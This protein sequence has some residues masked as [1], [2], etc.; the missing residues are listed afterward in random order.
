[1]TNDNIAINR[2]KSLLRKYK[3]GK[4]TLDNLVYII[5]DQGYEIIEYSLNE[6]N[7]ILSSLSLENYSQGC[8]AFSYN[9]NG[10]KFVFIS[11]DTSANEKTYALSHELGH[12]ACGHM[13]GNGTSPLDVEEEQEANEFAHYIL[14]PD[15]MTLAVA[16]Y[17]ENKKLAII[18]MVVVAC[19][20]IAIPL[21]SFLVKQRSC[22]GEFYV[23]ET[24]A[25]YHEKNCIF[26]KDKKNVSRLTESDY[27]SG[28]Y[29]PCQ[30]CLP[31]D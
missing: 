24:G 12:I 9:G 7:N 3:L 10:L 8:K 31:N 20:L 17:H 25:C 1:M 5:E 23:T 4:I 29:D 15:I 28:K 18:T 13:K 30:I 11:D 14:H 2:A 26:V 6:N 19:L 22:Y 16:K 27:Y 21:V